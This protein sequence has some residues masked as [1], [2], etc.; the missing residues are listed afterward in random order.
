VKIKNYR[1]WKLKLSGGFYIATKNGFVD[2]KANNRV[3]I[4]RLIDA[5]EFVELSQPINYR[6]SGSE[7]V[8][9]YAKWRDERKD[10]THHTVS[11][12]AG[13]NAAKA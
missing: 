9:A 5:R 2:L 6:R 13:F 3:G 11:F 4:E 10:E 8:K 12:V 1:G 7:V